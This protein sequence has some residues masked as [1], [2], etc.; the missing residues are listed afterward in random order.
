M[1]GSRITA[2]GNY[3]ICIEEH[4]V[5]LYCHGMNTNDPKE[6]IELQQPNYANVYGPMM[7]F[8]WQCSG[9]IMANPY[10]YAG[11]SSYDVTSYSRL[12]NRTNRLYQN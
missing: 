12:V 2:D 5:S 3:E 6:Y 8:G 1:E 9:P 11:N 10:E 4:K 7:E